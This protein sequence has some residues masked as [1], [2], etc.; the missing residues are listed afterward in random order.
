MLTVVLAM[1]A[2]FGLGVIATL[3]TLAVIFSKY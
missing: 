1:I 3:I 2:G